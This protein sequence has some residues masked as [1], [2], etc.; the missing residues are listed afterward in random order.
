FSCVCAGLDLMAAFVG[1]VVC[2]ANDMRTRLRRKVQRGRWA[3]KPTLPRGFPRL[4]AGVDLRLHKFEVGPGLQNTR[5]HNWALN[6]VFNRLHIG[7]F[8]KNALYAWYRGSPKSR[9]RRR[10]QTHP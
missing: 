10:G 3:V 9:Q 4:L 1:N 8:P 7:F 5:M 6:V 2:P